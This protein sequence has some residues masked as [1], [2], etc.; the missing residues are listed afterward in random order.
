M[1]K[2]SLLHFS[3]V[4]CEMEIGGFFVQ[5]GEP[6]MNE[7]CVNWYHFN[8]LLHG[9]ELCESYIYFVWLRSLLLFMDIEISLCSQECTSGP[10]HEGVRSVS[11]SGPILF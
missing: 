11:R 3:V 4:Y 8:C 2:I 5:M 7:N 9:A 1:A 10:C 6:C